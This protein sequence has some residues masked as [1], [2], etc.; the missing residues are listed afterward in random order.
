MIS[1]TLEFT[2]DPAVLAV[3]STGTGT[4]TSGWSIVRQHRDPGP[5]AAVARRH[6]AGDR[7]WAT[8][9]R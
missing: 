5:R 6:R 8:S 9:P 1:A 3:Q 2:F 7:R 4:L